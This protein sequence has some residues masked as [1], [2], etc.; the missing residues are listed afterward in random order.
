MVLAFAA[1]LLQFGLHHSSF[2]NQHTLPKRFCK[3]VSRCCKPICCIRPDP[4]VA[5][6][7]L[8]LPMCPSPSLSPEDVVHAIC[9]GLQFNDVPTVNTGLPVR[10]MTFPI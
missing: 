5:L 8:S 1:F 10:L 4:S 9:K 6:A 3:G 2:V 7:A